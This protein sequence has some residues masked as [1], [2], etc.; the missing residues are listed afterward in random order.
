MIYRILPDGFC[1]MQNTWSG[2]TTIKINDVEIKIPLDCRIEYDHEN[3]IINIIP[4][5]IKS[6]QG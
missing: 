4:L 1:L 6:N 5:D 2:T 3:K